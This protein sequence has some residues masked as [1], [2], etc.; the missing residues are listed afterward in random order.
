V[1]NES[2]NAIRNLLE[3]GCPKKLV[4]GIIGKFVSKHKNNNFFIKYNPI[5]F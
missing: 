4:W 1:I 2:Q 5:I 3:F